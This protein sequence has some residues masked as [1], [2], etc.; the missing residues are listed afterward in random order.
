MPL[1]NIY[2]P[3][4]AYGVE[5]KQTM[6]ASI[7]RLYPILPKFYVG[8]LFHEVSRENFYIGGVANDKFV[9]ISV[10]HIARQFSDDEI[11]ERWLGWVTKTLAPFT[12]DRG[13]DWELHID[14]TPF[15]IWLMQGMRPPL[16]NSEAETK[17][18]SENRPSPYEAGANS[19]LSKFER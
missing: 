12:A 1:W 3:V 8:V 9:R 16:P 13:L 4:D 6:A 18:I 10:D 19:H 5:D 2:H 17:W 11:R 7:V 15:H 14:E